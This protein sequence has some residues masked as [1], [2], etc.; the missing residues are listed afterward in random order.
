MFEPTNPKFTI[1]VSELEKM[2][3]KKRNIGNEIAEL[4]FIASEIDDLEKEIT[5]LDKKIMSLTNQKEIKIKEL[6]ER[7][8]KL[9]G[10]NGIQLQEDSDLLGKKIQEM[11]VEIKSLIDGDFK[12]FMNTMKKENIMECY[13]LSDTATTPLMDK[14]YNDKDK[15]FLVL[16]G[17]FY[18]KDLVITKKCR[19]VTVAEVS[20]PT[21]TE[22]K[23]FQSSRKTP[24]RMRPL[25]EIINQYRNSELKIGDK[26]QFDV[27]LPLGGQTYANQTGYGWEWDWS[28]GYGSYTEGTYYGEVTTFLIIGFIKS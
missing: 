23:R 8:S 25:V 19:N 20:A 5:D 1:L 18:G 9:D 28:Y 15:D 11:E 12:T 22:L 2:R 26:V 4:P 16:K 3:D 7:K 6:A 13:L 27:P 24:D 21:M 17:V 14:F 10:K